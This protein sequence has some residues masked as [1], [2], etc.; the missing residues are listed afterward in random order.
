MDIYTKES[1]SHKKNNM[2]T[3]NNVDGTWVYYV[4]KN[5]PGTGMQAPY[6]LQ[7]FPEDKRTMGIYQNMKIGFVRKDWSD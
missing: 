5:N 2:S 1:L 3:S 6:E 7:T 4:K